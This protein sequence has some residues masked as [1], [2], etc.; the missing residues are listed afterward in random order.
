MDKF[1]RLAWEK[2][3]GVFLGA[4]DAPGP[5]LIIQDEFHLI[6]GPLGTIVGLYEA[7]FDSRWPSTPP[8]QRSSRQPPRSAARWSRSKGVF[9]RKVAIFPPV[10]A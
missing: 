4:G 6:S 10:G 8:G 7:A 3:A 5:S 1:A 9:G 2:R